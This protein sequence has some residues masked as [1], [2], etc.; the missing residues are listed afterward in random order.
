MPSK[1]AQIGPVNTVW[2]LTRIQSGESDTVA[3]CRTVDRAETQAKRIV[4]KTCG[5]T[6]VRTL[7]WTPSVTGGKFLVYDKGRFSFTFRIEPWS[8]DGEVA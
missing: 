7:P 8:V 3:V 2:I 1:Y 5:V 6:S 4:A